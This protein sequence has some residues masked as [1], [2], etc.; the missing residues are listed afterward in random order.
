[1][2][3]VLPLLTVPP[4]A[5]NAPPI[6]YSPPEIEIGDGALIP[7][8]VIKPDIT[9]VFMGAFISVVK[10]KES[11]VVSDG[12]TALSPGRTAQA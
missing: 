10:V 6:E 3:T 7:L 5:V 12:P 2:R 8:T 11:G 1:M 9:K 4:D